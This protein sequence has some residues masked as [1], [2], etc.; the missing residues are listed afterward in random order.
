[1]GGYGAIKCGLRRPDVFSRAAGLSSAGSRRLTREARPVLS[2][3]TGLVYPARGI[4]H[5][6]LS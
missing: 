2:V 4:W 3:K 5:S 1:M 6:E